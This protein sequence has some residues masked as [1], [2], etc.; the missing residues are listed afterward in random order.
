MAR[1]RRTRGGARLLLCNSGIYCANEA[2]G[3]V[4][5]PVAELQEA[6]E[7]EALSSV[8]ALHIGGCIAMCSHHN[9]G[10]L[11]TPDKDMVLTKLDSEG[12]AV[13]LAWARASKEAGKLL[14]LPT[15]LRAIER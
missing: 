11:R 10:F 2:N 9:S 14:A 13:V 15:Q 5:V 6:W 3:Q 12:Y 8:C 4:A 1:T 7:E